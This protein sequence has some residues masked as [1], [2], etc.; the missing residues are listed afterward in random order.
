MSLQS[1]AWFRQ[2]A[3]KY[4]YLFTSGVGS[5]LASKVESFLAS[6]EVT[7]LLDKLANPR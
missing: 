3:R 5:L 1:V 7:E 4:M 2:L 6:A